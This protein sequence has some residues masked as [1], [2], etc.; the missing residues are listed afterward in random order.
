M[1]SPSMVMVGTVIR[2]CR[3]PLFQ[4]VVF[5]L[6]L[7]QTEPP[8]IVMDDDSDVIG[9]FEGRRR[10]IERDL[11]NQ[12]RKVVPVFVVACAAAFRGEV[13]LVRAPSDNSTIY[14]T[15]VARRHSSNWKTRGSRFVA[16]PLLTVAITG[17]F[18]R[19]ERNAAAIASRQF[20]KW[21]CKSHG[22]WTL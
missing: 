21:Y 11:P 19:A 13:V 16:A 3:K 22:K 9:V 4:I 5:G 17:S 6:A 15:R 1:A 10:A 20:R 12:L 14:L 7:R 18:G 8:A 2:T